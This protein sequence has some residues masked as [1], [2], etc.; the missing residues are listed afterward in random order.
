MLASNSPLLWIVIAIAVLVLLDLHRRTVA[1]STHVNALL[2]LKD[3][4]EQFDRLIDENVS[5]TL[6][7]YSKEKDRLEERAKGLPGTDLWS[8]IEDNHERNV[9]AAAET[10]RDLIGEAYG[11]DTPDEHFV[12]QSAYSVRMTPDLAHDLV[13]LANLGNETELMELEWR[14]KKIEIAG[15]HHKSGPDFGLIA[16]YEYELLVLEAKISDQRHECRAAKQALWKSFNEARK[17]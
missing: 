10:L 9:L 7:W 6:N 11:R 14:I 12:M 8:V 13:K 1:L 16:S 3:G 17:H 15:E 4:D 2:A 5:K